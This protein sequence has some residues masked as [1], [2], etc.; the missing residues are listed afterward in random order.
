LASSPCLRGLAGGQAAEDR[1]LALAA[2][3]QA[4]G[5]GGLLAVQ[6]AGHADLMP[7]RP[8]AAAH[9]GSGR[10]PGAAAARAVPGGAGRARGNHLRLGCR[11]RAGRR[12]AIAVL[13][14]G[15]V[16]VICAR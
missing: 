14:A 11:A 1:L 8:A 5:P 13:P 6:D 7:G 2:D 10:R 12:A 9:P 3:L 15:G 4:A 16:S